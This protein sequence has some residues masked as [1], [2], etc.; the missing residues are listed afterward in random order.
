[1]PSGFSPFISCR[2]ER[3]VTPRSGGGTEKNSRRRVA[4]WT[5]V[6]DVTAIFPE[7]KRQFSRDAR[8]FFPS[9][10]GG[11]PEARGREL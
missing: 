7:G 9:V 6:P 11:V 10:L 5:L 8:V 3:R 1:M 2:C 4:D